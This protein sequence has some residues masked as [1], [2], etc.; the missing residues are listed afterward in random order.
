MKQFMKRFT[1]RFAMVLATVLVITG[2]PLIDELPVNAANY[3]SNLVTSYDL[4]SASGVTN[5][6]V[7]FTYDSDAGATV[8]K[9]SGSG[10]S[11][12]Y[13]KLPNSAF[14]SV[15]A[16]TGMTISLWFKADSSTSEWSRLFDLGYSDY[17]SSMP[18]MFLTPS[19]QFS[20]NSHNG[21]W[22]GTVTTCD[23]TGNTTPTSGAWNHAVVS[24]SSSKIK[25]FLNGNLVGEANND[26]SA[27]LN[28]IS[29]F[30]GLDLGRSKYMADS[31]YVGYM[32][33]FR[34]YNT[35]LSDSDVSDL[36][37]NGGGSGSGSA[38]GS[39]GGSGS[40]SWSLID[41]N[42]AD[43][44]DSS[45]SFPSKPTAYSYDNN[46]RQ[47]VHDPSLIK[48]GNYYY[49]YST[50]IVTTDV[51]IRRSTDLINWTYVG[52]AGLMPANP[53][54][55]S[56]ISSN[57]WAPEVIKYGNEYRMYY[58]CSGLNG[59]NS[60]IAL[61]TATNPAG[62][63][64]HKGIVVSSTTSEWI[65][66]GVN[67]IDANIVYDTSGNMYM[68]WGS[69]F[70]GIKIAQMDASTGYLKSTN[71]TIIAKRSSSFDNGACEGPFVFYNE[72]TGYY[73]LVVSYGNLLNVD[74]GGGGYSMRVGRSKSITGPYYDYNG[75]AMTDTSVTD[76]Q[77]GYKLA[78]NYK[79]N[80]GSGW[81]AIGGN[82]VYEENGKWYC[83]A[84]A[85]VNGERD[86]VFVNIRQMFWSEDGWPLCNPSLYAGEREQKVA[87]DYVPGK[88]E[89]IEFSYTKEGA[90][91]TASSMYLY[92]DYTASVKGTSGTWSY[93][94]TNTVTVKFGNTTE[95][96]K[97][98]P[99]WDWENN[100]ATYFIM[101][102][103]QDNGLQRW[104]KKVGYYVMESGNTG[105]DNTGSDNT[106]SDNTGSDNTGSDNT[107]SDNTG[108]GN[109]G[110][111][112]T[113]SG[114][115]DSGNT[116]S[117]N[118]G[119]GSTSSSSLEGVYYI[120][121]V[122]SGLY[123]DVA[124]G[125]SDNNANIQQWSYNGYDAQKFK[126]VS[127]GNDYYHILTGASGYTKCVD[128]S[129]GKAADGTNILQ[130][131]YKGSTNQQF[132]IELQSDGTY[133]ILTRA[134]NCTGGLDVYD[135][136]TE[137][138]G[139]VNQWNFWGGACQKWILE[140]AN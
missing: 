9:F 107:G 32:K 124:N 30:Y 133:A 19:M 109:T 11:T 28:N 78:T 8:A 87:V 127:D 57:L 83:V 37:V 88:Y 138:G 2:F 45:I 116:G 136:S 20:Y 18:Y 67:A 16:S 85:R 46:G 102:I 89:R 91:N 77:V 82:S 97:I 63:F 5:T 135:W 39:T 44:S 99:S 41:M 104:G 79:F 84:H 21:S 3:D 7:S 33:D 56:Y 13:L 96:Y 48:V 66:G 119:S 74:G 123:L 108:S 101:G 4:S 54:V 126:L 121:N 24:L 76:A 134:S 139:N 73:Y 92:P 75:I 68:V 17:G 12:S 29:Q 105:S 53:S 26:N 132:K 59:G 22:L 43:N 114:N 71:G 42:A 113:G 58:S 61:A 10:H 60:C 38:G 130:Y 70:G 64:T 50:G 65:A 111:G 40:A 27:I 137:A 131:T 34:V 112:N 69:F 118:T 128:V 62:P 6:N 125:S 1:K 52:A 129:G 35:A 23:I 49:M 122:N 15:K 117:G 115:T 80:T 36:Y 93:S 25:L 72:D 94:G 106:G 90:A 81:M 120:K 110:S 51:E 55:S 95:E 14:S 98:V 31:D 86:S 47:N 140:P 100:K 103:N